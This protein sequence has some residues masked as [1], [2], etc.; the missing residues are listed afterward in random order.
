MKKQVFIING[1]GGVGKDTLVSLVQKHISAVNI[2]SVDEVKKFATMMGW[3]GKKDEKSR[4][5]LSDLKNILIEY[6]DK[7]FSY[8]KES[9]HDF[10][11]DECNELCFLHIRE[12]QE[13]QRAKEAFNAITILVTRDKVKQIR[14]NHADSD[15]LDYSYDYRV[16]N[17][18][19]LED[20]EQMAITF[21][22]N[23]RE[24]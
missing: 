19:S 7:P 9:V 5:F 24:G 15:V 22:H 11:N 18:G 8:L 12:P 20:L 4:K 10:L 13:I 21:I 1:S 2:S 17:N 14:S 23:I 3:D 16:V 6:N